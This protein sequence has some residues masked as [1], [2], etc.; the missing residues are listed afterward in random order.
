MADAQMPMG[1]SLTGIDTLSQVLSGLLL[2]VLLFV[3]ISVVEATYKAFTAMWKDRVELFPDTITSGS[4]VSTVIQDPLNPNAKTIYFSDN[5]RSGVEFTYAT[6]LYIGSATFSNGDHSLYHIMHKGYNKSYP[7]MGPGI[8]SWGDSNKI[9]IFMN[10]FD[11]WNNYC[12]ISN[13]P[14]DKWFHLVITCKGNVVYIYINGNIKHQLSLNTSSNANNPSP[15]YQNYGNVYAF[16]SRKV[17][18]SSSVTTSLGNDPQF[19]GTNSPQTQMVFNGAAT[20]MLSRTYY[21]SYAI[22]Y[23]EIQYLMNMGPSKIMAGGV[24]MSISPYLADTWWTNN[25]V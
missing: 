17:T 23:T 14:V 19:N 25:R 24:D 2:V 15:P 6:F 22:T 10:S 18:L 8:F 13:I 1:V 16:N 11:S 9:R 4:S 21:F 12:D 20:G 3:I 7:L 5:Q